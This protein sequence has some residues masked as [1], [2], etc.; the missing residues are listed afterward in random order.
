MPHNYTRGQKTIQHVNRI[1]KYQGKGRD[2]PLLELDETS[3]ERIWIDQADIG[4]LVGK[5]HS[6]KEAMEEEFKGQSFVRKLSTLRNESN[7]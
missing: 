2:K 3:E 1:F 4:L 6:R 7:C 5:Y